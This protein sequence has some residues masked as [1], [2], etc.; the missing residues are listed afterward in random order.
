[1]YIRLWGGRL[2]INLLLIPAA[3]AMVYFAGPAV[4]G[5]FFL[6]LLMHEAAHALIARAVGARIMSL[7][8]LPFGC[9]A[10][11]DGFFDSGAK[12]AAVAAA[13]PLINIAAAAGVNLLFPEDTFTSAFVRSSAALS[14]VNLLPAL[15]MDGGRI[16]AAMLGMDMKK[17]T[18]V[19]I[20]GYLGIAAGSAVILLFAAAA[21]K[22]SLNFTLA[23]MGG[24]MLYSSVK[25]VKSAGFVFARQTQDK[26]RAMERRTSI[27][28]KHVAARDDRPLSEVMLALDPRKYNIVHVLDSE[29]NTVETMDEAAILSR[30]LKGES[31][32]PIGRAQ[33]DKRMRRNIK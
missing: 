30:M 24:F 4:F 7:E 11:M 5:A 20:S 9:A 17:Q 31:G 12:E 22:G 32:E 29:L 21:L 33:V 13:G 25:S 26:R 14:A 27:D 3:A 1:M 6:A 19:R 8:L 28:V 16:L 10:N 18:A 23:A 15:P 2:K